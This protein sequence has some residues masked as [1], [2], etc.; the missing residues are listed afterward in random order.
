MK[1]SQKNQVQ[2][3]K[4]KF[5]MMHSHYDDDIDDE[6]WLLIT[7]F[8]SII[9]IFWGVI[10]L[11]DKF[12][13]NFMPWWAEPLTIFPIGGYFTV[14]DFFGRNPL[15]WWPMIWGY[16]IKMPEQERVV[17]RPIDGDALVKK[18]GGPLNVYVVDPNYIKF[19]KKKDA[20][21]YCLFN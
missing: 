3:Y 18:Y 4:Q 6:G 19:R 20:V 16:K 9:G 12:T 14:A 11:V 5:N 1:M 8:A 10:H 13:F 15:H 7:I 2:L 21:K 17:L